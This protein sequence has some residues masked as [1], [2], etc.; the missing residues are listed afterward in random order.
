MCVDSFPL[1]WKVFYGI[2]CITIRWQCYNRQSFCM[3]S[4]SGVNF[5][6]PC[7]RLIQHRTRCVV[8]VVVKRYAI[9]SATVKYMLVYKTE[10]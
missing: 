2:G 3:E 1:G 5:F 10:V 6:L 4:Y 7:L 8:V 9:G